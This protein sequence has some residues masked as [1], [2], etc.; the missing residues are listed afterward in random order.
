MFAQGLSTLSGEPTR[1]AFLASFASQG[2]FDLGGVNLEFGAGDNQGLDQV[3]LTV[4]TGSGAEPLRD[5]ALA[6]VD[7]N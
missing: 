3:W 1:E 4:L 6:S 5:P 2:S 7:D